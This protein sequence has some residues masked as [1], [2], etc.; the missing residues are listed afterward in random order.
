MATVSSKTR[1]DKMFIFGVFLWILIQLTPE[2]VPDEP[3]EFRY[4]ML[5]AVYEFLSEVIGYIVPKS[6][7]LW[8][9]T[10]RL[11]LLHKK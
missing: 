11:L 5:L 10:S 9:G 8:Q 3:Y 7:W 6:C 1:P 4:Q 2:R